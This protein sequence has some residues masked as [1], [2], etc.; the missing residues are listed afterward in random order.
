MGDEL[1]FYYGAFDNDH[2]SALPNSNICLAKLR[3]D[4]FVS[5]DADA[6]E[7]TVVTRPFQCGGGELLVNSSA[8]GGTVS[9]AVL[10]EQGVEVKGYRAVDC[11][12]FDGN[13]VR[14]RVTWRDNVSLEGTK[15][16]VVRL[17]FYLRNAKLYSFV[18]R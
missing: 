17:K 15:G 5:M 12:V 14:H 11:A 8:R 18:E 9:V 13:S 16:S 10:D 2:A 6:H 1:W 4:G 3:L 7:G